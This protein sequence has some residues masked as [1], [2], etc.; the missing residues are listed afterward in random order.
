MVSLRLKAGWERRAV[1]PLRPIGTLAQCL[2]A[3]EGAVGRSIRMTRTRA[4]GRRPDLQQSTRPV[5][6]TSSA[7]SRADVAGVGA[8]RRTSSVASLPDA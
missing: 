6:R 8:V 2:S 3:T 1:L 4:Q 5:R 7:Q